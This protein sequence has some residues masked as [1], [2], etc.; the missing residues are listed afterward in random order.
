MSKNK[1]TVTH[2][3]SMFSAFLS[4]LPKKEKLAITEEICEKNN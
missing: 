1:K 4:F 2:N 3:F